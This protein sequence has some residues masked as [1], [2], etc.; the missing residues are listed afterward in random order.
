M[1][2][3]RSYRRPQPTSPIKRTHTAGRIYA[4]VV[5]SSQ[6]A[7]APAS[8]RLPGRCPG[9]GNTVGLGADGLPIH[10][11]L[12]LDRVNSNICQRHLCL[13]RHAWCCCFDFRYATS[14]P[15]RGSHIRTMY[16]REQHSSV[17]TSW[18]RCSSCW[19]CCSIFVTVYLIRRAWSQNSLETSG[20]E[21]HLGSDEQAVQAAALLPVKPPETLK[22]QVTYCAIGPTQTE[23]HPVEPASRVIVCCLHCC[24][25]QVIVEATA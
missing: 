21:R 19:I 23:V 20:R 11:I 10:K 22:M 25:E 16:G 17:R 14:A 15:N 13:H 24:S 6:A 1:K 12:L 5:T 4:D 7:C 3:R 18:D 2:L 9:V 8:S